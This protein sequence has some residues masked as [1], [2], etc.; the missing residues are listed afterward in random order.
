MKRRVQHPHVEEYQSGKRWY[1]F[2]RYYDDVIQPDGSVKAIRKRHICGFSRGRRKGQS[3]GDDTITFTQAEQIRDDFLHDLNAAPTR[4]QAAMRAQEEDSPLV[5]DIKFG[6]LAEL[7][8]KDYVDNP[9]VRL[10]TPT[11]IKYR[12]RL[13]NHIL[14]RWKDTRLSE[15]NDSK[16][17]LDW[18]HSICTSWYM[19]IDLRNTMSGIITRAQEWN[20]IPRSL[21]NPW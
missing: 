12:D 21:A 3:M 17:V 14:P 8:R 1:Y 19:M 6:R 16:A 18:L 10:A 7:W 15:L 2:F 13:E 9:M 20:I 11:R 5:G 4:T